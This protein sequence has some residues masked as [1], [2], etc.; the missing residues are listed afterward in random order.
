MAEAIGAGRWREY[1]REAVFQYCEED[2]RASTVLL[3]RQL[4]GYG[5]ARPSI[6][7]RVMSWSIYSAK[8]VARIQ[9][10][11]MPIDMELWNLAQENEQ[12]V[13]GALI[14]R[15]DPSQAARTRSIPRMA[16]GVAIG[17]RIGW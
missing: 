13:I 6:P 7:P 5:R 8:T 9:A 11:G 16:S 12:A 10:R 15:V 2:V 4:A 14:R 3:R 17:S 1:G